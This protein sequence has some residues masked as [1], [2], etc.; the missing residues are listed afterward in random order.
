MITAEARKGTE[1]SDNIIESLWEEFEDVLFVEDSS[2][3]DSCKLVL[4]SDWENETHSFSKGTTRD[5]IW[6][7][8]N[9]NHSKG[10][11]WLLNGYQ[12]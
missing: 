1:T 7:W 4:A 12:S 10:I 11:G 3:D 5:S 9:M 8:F 6:C 2:S